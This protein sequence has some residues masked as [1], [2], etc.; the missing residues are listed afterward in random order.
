MN[1]TLPTPRPLAP[2]AKRRRLILLAVGGYALA[3]ASYLAYEAFR[4]SSGLP[5]VVGSLVG[6]LVM[7]SGLIPLLKPSRLGLPEGRNWQMDERQWQRLSE[8]HLLA[9]RLLGAVFML[10]AFY[11]YLGHKNGTLPLPTSNYAWLTIYMGAIFFIPA[12]PTMILAWTEPDL[13]D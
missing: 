6:M 3:I 7:M 4:A 12:L 11:F 10:S 8:A 13:Q 9:Y 1:A 2:L 5:F